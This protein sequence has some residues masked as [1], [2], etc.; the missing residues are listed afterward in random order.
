M[1]TVCCEVSSSVFRLVISTVSARKLSGE[2]PV[3]GKK[4]SPI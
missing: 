2:D 3:R 1:F 4:V